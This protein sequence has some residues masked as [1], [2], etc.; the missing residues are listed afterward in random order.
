MAI[1][2]KETGPGYVPIED[3]DFSASGRESDELLSDGY[4]TA[5]PRKSASIKKKIFI[6]VG[7]L[8]ALTAYSILL[9]TVVSLWWKKERVH[10]A[11]VIDSMISISA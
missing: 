9:T 11:N 5:R 7:S 6:A 8:V 1:S 3:D 10:G 4:P 2:E